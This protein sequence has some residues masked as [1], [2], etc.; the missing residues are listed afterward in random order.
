MHTKHCTDFHAAH[1][2][3]GRQKPRGAGAD[4]C[5]CFMARAR[6]TMSEVPTAVS[7]PRKANTCQKSF[8]SSEANEAHE[9]G[10]HP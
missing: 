8:P 4:G 2:A 5:V 3:L 6:A 1:A 10:A 7:K 9:R